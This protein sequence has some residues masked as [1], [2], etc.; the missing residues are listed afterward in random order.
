M[1]YLDYAASHPLTGRARQALR[2]AEDWYA[3]PS[4]PHR[5]GREARK[6]VEECRKIMREIFCAKKTYE[7]IF[8]SGATESNNIAILGRDYSG[9]DEILYSGVAHS[10]ILSPLAKSGAKL[11]P[12]LL[13]GGRVTPPSVARSLSPA[14]KLLILEQVNSQTGLICDIESCLESVGEGVHVHVDASQGFTKLPLSLKEEWVDSLTLSGHKIGAPRGVGLLVAKRY[15]VRPILWGGGQEGGLRSG[16]ENLAAMWA[17]CQCAQEERD[18]SHLKKLKAILLRGLVERGAV[19]PFD[20]DYTSSHI[21]A[22]LYPKEKGRDVVSR[23]SDDE[24]FVS[25]VSACAGGVGGAGD[26]LAAAGLNAQ[27]AEHLLRVSLSVQSTVEHVERLLS[28]LP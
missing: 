15:T 26:I 18:L 28:L 19:F 11:R 14:T 25:Q 9:E 24:V 4:S 6:K 3:N 13:D 17:F 7:I 22:F 16:T 12:L 10:S 21:C 2:E 1:V 23:L 27:D 5:L 8:T 20:Q